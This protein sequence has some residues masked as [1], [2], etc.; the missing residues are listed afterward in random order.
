MQQN[1]IRLSHCFCRVSST[2]CSRHMLKHLKIHPLDNIQMPKGDVFNGIIMKIITFH[3]LINLM[4]GL[5]F[6]K[7]IYISKFSATSSLLINNTNS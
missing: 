2:I 6:S 5:D 3:L 7:L 4:R 1:Y